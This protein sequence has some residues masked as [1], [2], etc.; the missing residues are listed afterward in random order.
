MR[1]NEEKTFDGIVFYGLKTINECKCA[2]VADT[3]ET[4]TKREMRKVES[5]EMEEFEKSRTR[6][7]HL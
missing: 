3:M 1:T 7:I 4:S 5:E 6:K 2:S